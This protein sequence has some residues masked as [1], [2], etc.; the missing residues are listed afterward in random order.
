MTDLKQNQL[1]IVAQESGLESGKVE[2]LLQSFAGYFDEARKLAAE[3]KDI[4]V[5][6]ESQTEL[7]VK[8]RESRL[9]LKRVR[10]DVENTRKQLKE[11]S[12]RE[13]RAIDGISNLIKALIVPVEEH[14][15]KQEKYAEI[16]ELERI[17]KRHEQRILALQPLVDDVSVFNLRDM[18]DAAFDQLLKSSKEAHE[19]KLA[20][21][22][23]AEEDRLV[24]EKRQK[25]LNDRRIELAP[26]QEFVDINHPGLI[27][28]SEDEYQ[29]TLEGAKAKKKANDDEQEKIRKENEALRAKEEA[30]RQAKEA[31]E[32]KLRA[33]KEAQE[34]KEREAREAEE[35]NKRAEEE[36]E[37]KALLSPDKE[38]LLIFAM[39]LQKIKAPAVKSKEADNILEAAMAKLTDAWETLQ[40]GAN[41]L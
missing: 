6:D 34:K 29:K 22:R 3:S 31:A 32:A 16:K 36:A 33:E 27:D 20:A 10:V 7:M 13:G 4:I 5:T 30:A 39:E 14:L 25:R 2:G 28:M 8:A 12:L 37:R 18:S 40:N 19:A 26:Y 38:K 35:A 41:K 24:E 21:E 17:A 9:A 15:E 11:Q 23:K 1:A